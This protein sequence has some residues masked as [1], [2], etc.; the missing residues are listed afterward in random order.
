[1]ANRL[2]GRLLTL[3]RPLMVSAILVRLLE[4]AD[5]ADTSAII[6][7]LFAAVLT[8]IGSNGI[9]AI[10]SVLSTLANL[11]ALISDRFGTPI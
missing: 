10:G 3:A 9:Q 2:F 11:S 7:P 8:V 1:M 4:T 6:R 5:R